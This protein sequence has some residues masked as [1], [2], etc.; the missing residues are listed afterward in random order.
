M[1]ELT[2]IILEFYDKLSSWEHE[3]VRN[4]GISLAQ[5]HA[6]EVIGFYG[7]TNARDAASKLGV[8][9]GTLTVMMNTLEVKGYIKKERN[10]EDSRSILISLSD[11]GNSF[12]EE[13]HK[14]HHEMVTE[15]SS[16]CSEEELKNLKKILTKL[17]KSF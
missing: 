10:P 3:L 11:K 15:I 16:L 9:T 2:N 7:K 13:H 17:N 5:M 8:T 4:S 1:K 6:M 14:Y 12:Y